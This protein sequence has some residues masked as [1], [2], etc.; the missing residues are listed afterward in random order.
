MLKQEINKTKIEVLTIGMSKI[1]STHITKTITISTIGMSLLPILQIG[2]TTSTIKM[3]IK[4]RE[5]RIKTMTSTGFK[6]Q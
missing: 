2:K 6:T 3:D 5:V 1:S 4:D